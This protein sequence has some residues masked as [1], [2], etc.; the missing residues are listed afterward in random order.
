MTEELKV[1]QQTENSD[2]QQVKK[3]IVEE[4]SFKWHLRQ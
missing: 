4:F 1:Q 3:E 2:K